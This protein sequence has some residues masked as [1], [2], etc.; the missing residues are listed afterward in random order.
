MDV[1]VLWRV[2][3]EFTIKNLRVIMFFIHF[4]VSVILFFLMYYCKK[5]HIIKEHSS[6]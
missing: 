4:S 1:H 6:E 3:R 2:N 5:N